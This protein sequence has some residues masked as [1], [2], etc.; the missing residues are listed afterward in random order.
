LLVEV[1]T[2]LQRSKVCK[3]NET[4]VRWLWWSSWPH[5]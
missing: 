5:R 1:W 3:S 4:R 2:F